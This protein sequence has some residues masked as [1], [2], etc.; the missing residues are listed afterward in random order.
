M[1][2]IVSSS[3]KHIARGCRIHH[4]FLAQTTT[5]LTA[6]AAYMPALFMPHVLVL[7][8]LVIIL[9]ISLALLALLA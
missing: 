7:V 8:V 6:V 5:T 2:R 1:R 3:G 9:V 4:R